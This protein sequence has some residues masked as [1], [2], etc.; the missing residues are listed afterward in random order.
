MEIES[1]SRKDA[2]IATTSSRDAPPSGV[3]AAEVV[4]SLEKTPRT[5]VNTIAATQKDSSWAMV[6]FG[7]DMDMLP[8]DSH[9]KARTCF[10]H[11]FY[12]RFNADYT[13]LPL[14]ANA[15][16]T[17]FAKACREDVARPVEMHGWAAADIAKMLQEESDRYVWP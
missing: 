16:H 4:R 12:L 17:F 10:R 6:P 8:L 13:S 15:T 11:M 3:D 7:E 2:S 1:L 5:V 9:L 14:A